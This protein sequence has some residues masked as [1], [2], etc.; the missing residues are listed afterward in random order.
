MFN[1][2]F[3]TRLWFHTCMIGG[4][5]EAGRGPCIGPLVIAGVL[6]DNEQKLVELG[7]RDSKQLS[8]A[9]R[10][11]LAKQIRSQA[12]GIELIVI[13]A[14]DIDSMRKTMTMN[15]LE[16]FVFTKLI[17]K[18]HPEI[19][20]VDAVDVNDQRF[21]TNILTH[22]SFSPRI[23]SEHKADEKYPVVAAASIIAKTIRDEHIRKIANTLE[24]QLS[25]PMGSGYPADQQTIIFLQTWYERFKSFPTEVRHSWSTVQNIIDKKQKKTLDDYQ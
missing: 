3:Y 16:V 24:H 15:E 13:S 21:A 11:K 10:E 1:V 5:D 17:E 19:C 18:L 9:R 7:V 20:Y 12:H 14:E 22:L 23:I 6:I 25:M 4:I 8:P 2:L